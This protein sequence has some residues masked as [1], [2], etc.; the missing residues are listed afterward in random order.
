MSCL[1][2]SFEA[3]V[4]TLIYTCVCKHF[5]FKFGGNILISRDMFFLILRKSVF[6]LFCI[7]NIFMKSNFVI[8]VRLFGSFGLV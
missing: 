5:F 4:Y 3:R 7:F 8:R 6:P 1:Q 2:T